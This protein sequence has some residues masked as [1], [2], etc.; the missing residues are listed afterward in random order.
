MG[1][2]KIRRT[3][4]NLDTDLVEAASAVLGTE[5]TTDTVHAALRSV[6]DRASRERL[7]ERDFADL[8]PGVLARLRRPRQPA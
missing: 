5:R 6:I 7:V 4:I 3:N 2:T 8:T 1:E